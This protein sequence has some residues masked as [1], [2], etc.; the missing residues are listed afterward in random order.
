MI[1]IP[2]TNLIDKLLQGPDYPREKESAAEIDLERL[3]AADSVLT[4]EGKIILGQRVE[5]LVR[6]E[7]DESYRAAIWKACQVGLP[8]MPPYLYFLQYLA[9]IF[10]PRNLPGMQLLPFV[11]YPYQVE[12]LEIIHK[13]VLAGVGV[14]GK[15]G[16][17]LDL[18]SRDVGD[19]WTHL[20]YFA[21]DWLINGGSFHL[22]S[23]KE[24]E[25]D[26]LGTHNTLFGKL[27]KLLYSLPKWMLPQDLTDK[28]LLLAHNKEE[29]TISG[30]S[31]NPGFGRSKRCKAGLM[32]EFQ[33]WEHDHAAFQSFSSTTNTIFIIGTPRGFGNY[34]HEIASKKKVKGAVIRTIHWSKHPLKAKGGRI[35]D[36][37]FVS[38]WYKDQ[39]K[40]LPAEVVAAELDLSFETS[41]KGPVFAHIY[42]AGHQKKGLKIQPGL[43]LIRAWD[44]GGAYSACVLLQVDRDR[45]VR[46]YRE[47]LTL[48]FTLEEFVNEVFQVNEELARTS[49]A[50]DPSQHWKDFYTI[51]DVGDPSGATISKANQEV[52]EYQEMMD[53]WSINVDYLFMGT[54][55]TELRVRARNLQYANAMQRHVS[56]KNPDLDG[57]ALWIDVE[58]CPTLDEAFRGGY[59]RKLDIA[60]NVTDQ[61]EKRH[62][63]NDVVD[64]GGYGIVSV[65]GLPE[66][67]KRETKRQSEEQQ[68]DEDP[69]GDENGYSKAGGRSRC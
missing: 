56:S 30:E 42:G 26:K 1:I 27:R 65:L 18:K 23:F 12:E 52:P 6:A 5:L 16:T 59:R 55:P 53:R 48:G 64:A 68:E 69:Y 9:C 44:I 31:A 37:K 49:W 2:E 15:R 10:E 67:I 14:T 46:L 7:L 45:R 3:K 21:W 38:D 33:N 47:I 57:P 25:V 40:E 41:V 60:G 51:V 32:D 61:I 24:E 35:E 63:Y 54:M 22:G 4:E 8:G 43:P 34:Y 50:G 29:S 58:G 19:T 62:P 20:G 39:V 11:P 13:M 28:V 17:K 36:G 66:Q